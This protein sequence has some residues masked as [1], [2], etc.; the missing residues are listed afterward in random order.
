MDDADR[1]GPAPVPGPPTDPAWGDTDPGGPEAPVWLTP[2]QG[3]HEIGVVEELVPARRSRWWNVALA[4]VAVAALGV[5]VALFVTA[6]RGSLEASAA[7]A[8][9]ANMSQNRDDLDAQQRQVDD[10][11]RAMD[12][13]TSD[14]DAAM[15]RLEKA[16]TDAS[17][18]QHHL[19]EVHTRAAGLWNAGNR[20]GAANLAKSD[21]AAALADLDQKTAA[22]DKA[23]TDMQ[24]AARDLQ[25]K[26][27]G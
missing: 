21:G 22:V 10:R 19:V 5:A 3:D 27:D 14:L 17:G 11:R 8:Q 2:A 7:T 1:R 12:A 23:L 15:A 18:A 4:L 9:A 20:N 16:M 26:L 24:S 6:R 13:A 25:A